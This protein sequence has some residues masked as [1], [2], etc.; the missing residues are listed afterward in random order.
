MRK[1]MALRALFMSLMERGRTPLMMKLTDTAMLSRLHAME[2]CIGTLPESR[3]TMIP[4][5]LLQTPALSVMPPR[6]S[7]KMIG[8]VLVLVFFLFFFDERAFHH[9][10]PFLR[11]RCCL[12][13]ASLSA[14]SF[15]I[16][17]DRGRREFFFFFLYLTELVMRRRRRRLEYSVAAASS[18]V[19]GSRRD[20]AQAKDGIG[21]RG[22]RSQHGD[23]RR[24]RRRRCRR[25]REISPR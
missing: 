12:A 2:V 17:V 7:T 8:A 25:R 15:P 14:R 24:R 21:K 16:H 20:G 4:S 5:L 11:S 13:R 6:L 10:S 9:S 18:P 22:R 19:K 1:G 23:E 3:L